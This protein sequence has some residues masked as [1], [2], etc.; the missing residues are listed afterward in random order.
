LDETI[1][2]F[3]ARGQM[4]RGRLEDESDDEPFVTGSSPQGNA[5]EENEPRSIEE[6]ERDVAKA[7]KHPDFHRRLLELW[8]PDAEIREA[9][10]ARIVE[11]HRRRKQ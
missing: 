6:L 8:V 9:G 5:V 10:I 11:E 4:T 3:D 7:I 1:F 2:Y